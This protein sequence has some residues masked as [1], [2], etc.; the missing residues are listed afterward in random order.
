MKLAHWYENWVKYGQKYQQ[1]T[2]FQKFKEISS[3]LEKLH[4]ICQIT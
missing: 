1:H 3:S 4:E 2:F